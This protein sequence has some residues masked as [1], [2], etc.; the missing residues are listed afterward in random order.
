MLLQERIESLN[1]FKVNSEFSVPP[2]HGKH[3]A[4]VSCSRITH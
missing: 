1:V 3:L 2:D 4:Y